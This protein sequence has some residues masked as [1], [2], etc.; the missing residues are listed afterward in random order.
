MAFAILNTLF[1]ASFLLSAVVQYNDPDGLIWIAVYLGAAGM[2][3]AQML[4]KQPRWLPSVLLFISL[5]WIAI[6]LPS[7]VGEVSLAQIVESI[8]MQ[9]QAVEEAREIGGLFIVALWAACLRI[10]QHRQHQA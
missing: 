5:G 3:V 7:I 9:T 8:R 2:C 6:L 1:L 4:N 10:R